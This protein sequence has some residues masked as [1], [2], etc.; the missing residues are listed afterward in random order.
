MEDSQQRLERY[1]I[2]DRIAVGGM[3]EVFL[4]KV[5]G[6]HGFE[7][8]VA[9]KRILPELALDPEFEER[10]IAEAKVAVRLSHANI[11]QVFD[12]GRF[13]ESL[14]IAMEFVDGLDLAALLRYM[15]E[16]KRLVPLPTAFHIAIEIMRGLDFAHQHGVVHRDVSPSNILLSRAGEVKIADFGIAVAARPHRP[17]QPGPR[18]VMGKWRYM[19][20]EQTRGDQLD[21][22]SDVFSAAAVIFET[23]T[24]EKLFPGDDAEVISR[25]IAE[26]VIPKA[27]AMRAGLP[28]RLDEILAGPLS[29]RPNDRPARPAVIL[30]ALIEL[31]YE[32]SIV[33]T[34]LDLAETVALALS[35]PSGA[36]SAI[37]DVIRQQLSANESSVARQTAVTDGKP[38]MTAPGQLESTGLWLHTV[39]NDGVSRL[40]LQDPTIV[41]QPRSRRT[42]AMP[43][44][45]SAGQAA[46]VALAAP[47][48]ATLDIDRRT[49]VGAPPPPDEDASAVPA[50][51]P[52]ALAG[53][54]A[55]DAS[56]TVA[57]SGRGLA[58][59]TVRVP[60]QAVVRPPTSR[61]MVAGTLAVVVLGVGAM[62]WAIAPRDNAATNQ[63]KPGPGTAASNAPV[64]GGV[65]DL[66]S[67]P[68]GVEIQINGQAFG[69]TPRRVDVAAG[70]RLDVRLHKVGFIDYVDTLNL[71]MGAVIRIA[72]TLAVAPA[73]L[74]VATEPNGAT[75]TLA[76]RIIGVTPLTLTDLPPARDVQLAISKSGYSSYETKVSLVAGSPTVITQTL[77]ATQR[78][79]LVNISVQDASG[80]VS[81]GN[82]YLAGKFVGEAPIQGLRLPVGRHELV[83]KNS[84]RG[85]AKSIV[86]VVDDKRTRFY[87]VKFEGA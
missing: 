56:A 84:T 12:F 50:A 3:A 61:W 31:S 69:Q 29:R 21:T 20:P 37:D 26:M 34:S 25:N 54:G 86:I 51:E 67:K 62:W 41:A 39:G 2:V 52:L 22:R 42:S 14:F 49:E 1:D 81:A 38:S 68:E 10:F 74:E 8:T 28:P 30:R 64:S 59:T 23:F 16:A 75:V 6:A 57:A 55:T 87:L 66:A 43:A 5:Y 15:R 24:G 85:L 4:A 33:A 60:P 63:R 77:K 58:T 36:R 78:Y 82:L 79:G 11:V 72:P 80:G 46:A 45:E 9:I 83:L 35:P 71:P 76:G 19:S 27:S 53:N 32:S 70:V 40:E 44:V 48:V 17:G 7:K 13:G 18:K 73:Q 65:L 47:P